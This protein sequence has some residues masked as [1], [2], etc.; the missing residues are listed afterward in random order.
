MKYRASCGRKAPWKNVPHGRPCCILV[1]S[2]VKYKLMFWYLTA[3][4][5][6]ITIAKR[7]LTVTESIGAEELLEKAVVKHHCLNKDVVSSSSKVFYPQEK[8]PKTH[9]WFFLL[10]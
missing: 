9:T 2:C 8:I 6:I 3:C 7:G 4:L 5:L 10:T 1:N